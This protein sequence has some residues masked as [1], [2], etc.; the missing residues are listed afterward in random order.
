MKFFEKR[1]GGN[2]N[3]KINDIIQK[4]KKNIPILQ[5]KKEK[6]EQLR[7]SLAELN[8]SLNI[9]K[10]SLDENIQFTSWET[11]KDEIDRFLSDII[12]KCDNLL[13]R[14]NRNTV[15]IGV[16]GNTGQGKSILLQKISGLS[17]VQIPSGSDYEMTATKSLILNSTENYALLN[18]H[19]W[20]TFFQTKIK[21]LIDEAEITDITKEQD[22]FFSY[23]FKDEGEITELLKNLQKHKKRYLDELTGNTGK[24]VELDDLKNFVSYPDDGSRTGKCLAVKKADIFTNFPDTSVDKL[25]L[26]DLPGIGGIRGEGIYEKLY[27]EGMQI[28]C[29][30]VL[31]LKRVKKDDRID[32]NDFDRKMLNSVR[33]AGTDLG[34]IKDFVFLVLNSLADDDNKNKKAYDNITEL[35]N[36]GTENK[37]YTVLKSC[38]I[39]QNNVR[40]N[41][42]NPVLDHLSNTLSK[43]DETL[44][45]TLNEGINQQIKS[46]LEVIIELERKISNNIPQTA[47][48]KELLHN[49]ADNFPTVIN[50]L[51]EPIIK[52]CENISKIQMKKWLDSPKKGKKTEE[53][54]EEINILDNAAFDW[55][56]KVRKE[57][58]INIKEI[59]MSSDD[60]KAKLSSLQENPNLNRAK[61][62]S[63]LSK[64]W[65]N[66]NTGFENIVQ[67]KYN[68]IIEGFTR[69]L[70]AFNA[71]I[72]FDLANNTRDKV[73]VLADVFDSLEPPCIQISD[74]FRRLSNVNFFNK[75]IC[76][77]IIE[78]HCDKGLPKYEDKFKE[79]YIDLLKDKAEQVNYRIEQTMTKKLNFIA[80]GI[81]TAA[82]KD[83]RNNVIRVEEGKKDFR[84]LVNQ[85]ANEIWPEEFADIKITND[86]INKLKR[87]LSSIKDIIN[88]I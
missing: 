21:P 69:N 61:I 51:I 23:D 6:M 85:C 65:L 54:T 63:V 75:Y 12:S 86:K 11:R 37:N 45:N 88:N 27:F 40:E 60:F 77:S 33:N 26:I 76:M 84:R 53:K 18:M 58:D 16:A 48:V 74:A 15:N 35:V 41:I 9:A 39:D 8:T 73:R 4:R 24:R 52:K 7:N 44:L 55:L 43:M 56:I 34:N 62:I 82:I 46:I 83:F 87:N 2:T 70:G 79:Y 78:Y 47:D 28:N 38:V 5:Q 30:I 10:D 71:R 36:N 80:Y 31:F 29:D 68:Q 57:I 66:L 13:K 59:K 3:K 81:L 72:N 67:E 64:G 25:A 14:F 50:K 32:W 22:D 17:D 42:L 49:K 19:T 20:N 1:N